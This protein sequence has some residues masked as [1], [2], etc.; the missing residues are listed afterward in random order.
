ME[1]FSD[2]LFFLNDFLQQ[3]GEGVE[4]ACCQLHEVSLCPAVL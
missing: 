4:D 2:G 1:R 3:A